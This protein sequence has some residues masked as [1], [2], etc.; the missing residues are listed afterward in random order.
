MCRYYT[1]S[2]EK[3]TPGN[4]LQKIL[5][6]WKSQGNLTVRKSG[7][8]AMITSTG[9]YVYYCLSYLDIFVKRGKATELA[10]VF[11]EKSKTYVI[12]PCAL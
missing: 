5:E 2:K 7:N 3:L 11:V 6:K 10:I 1:N 8:H 4:L 9:N 12:V